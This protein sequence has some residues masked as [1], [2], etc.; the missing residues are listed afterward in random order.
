MSAGPR[1]PVGVPANDTPVKG[2]EMGNDLTELL[3]RVRL[4]DEH[5]SVEIIRRYESAVRVAVRTRLTDPRLRRQFDSL[6]VC[7]SVLASFFFRLTAGAY[8]LHAPEQ[9][10]ALLR[11]MA[12][13]KLGARTRDQFRHR[14]NVGRLSHIAVEQVRLESSEPEP[15]RQVL[16]QELLDR[17]LGMMTPEIRAIAVRRMEGELWPRIARAMGGTPDAR[18]KQ[19]ERAVNPIADTLNVHASER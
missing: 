12:Q 17:A 7:Q 6:D 18:R 16:T 2:T 1:E 15:S 10:L 9:L 13:N 14:R 8:D 5:A 4:G 11:K 3:Q 19:F